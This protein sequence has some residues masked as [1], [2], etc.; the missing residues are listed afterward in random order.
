MFIIGTTIVVSAVLF[1]RPAQCLLF[2]E[3]NQD[4]FHESFVKGVS[5]DSLSDFIRYYSSVPHIAGLWQDKQQAG[6]LN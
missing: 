6:T 1:S 2:P 5:N 4:K 3:R